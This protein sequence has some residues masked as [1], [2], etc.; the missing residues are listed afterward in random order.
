MKTMAENLALLITIQAL[1]RYKGSK[2]VDTSKLLLT[3]TS[4]G[5]QL[6]LSSTAN[7]LETKQPV[8]GVVA[9]APLVIGESAVPNH[10]KPKYISM[11]ENADGPLVDYSLLRQFMGTCVYMCIWDLLIA[12]FQ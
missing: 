6:A 8:Q 5:A 9:L 10:M 3:G 4:A 2:T 1:D 12:P 7:L 11:Q